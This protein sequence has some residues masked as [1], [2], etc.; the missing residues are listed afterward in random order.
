MA[1]VA[2]VV[3]S[4]QEAELIVGMLKNNGIHASV[5]AD[6]AGRVDLALQAQGVRVLVPEPQLARARRLL[7]AAPAIDAT[8]NRFQRLLVRL[9]GGG[10]DAGTK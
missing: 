4:R 7:D 9:L 6:D 2:A 10:S 3:G 5:S 8:L 1:V